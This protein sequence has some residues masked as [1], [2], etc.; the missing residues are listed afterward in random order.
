MELAVNRSKNLK[1]VE[2]IRE[3][4]RIELDTDEPTI[5]DCFISYIK[6]P[7]NKLN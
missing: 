2:L 5:V 6:Y 1:L 7:K 4:E 3:H